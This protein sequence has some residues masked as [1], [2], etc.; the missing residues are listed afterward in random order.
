MPAVVS[1]SL[2]LLSAV[3]VA[4]S[5]WPPPTLSD[6]P[7]SAAVADTVPARSAATAAHRATGCERVIYPPIVRVVMEIRPDH[8]PTPPCRYVTSLPSVPAWMH[9]PGARRA[10][11]GRWRGAPHA[12]LHA[13]NS[14]RVTPHGATGVIEFAPEGKYQG[15]RQ[16]RH[17]NDT[18][19]GPPRAQN[20]S[21]PDCRR[22]HRFADPCTGIVP[23]GR[24]RA[25][26]RHGPDTEVVRSHAHNRGRD[27]RPGRT[28]LSPLAGESVRLH[29]RRR[30]EDRRLRRN[31]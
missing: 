15:D 2:I 21:L 16:Y 4:L 23:R 14:N 17:G 13:G 7:V 18:A 29:D 20:H 11:T 8:S 9:G 3:R 10:C 5:V 12:A 25:R 27:P 22:E 24:P 26:T 30:H 6:Q 31:P 19:A 1:V 28:D